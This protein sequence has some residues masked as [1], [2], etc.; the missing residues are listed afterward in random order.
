[1]IALAFSFIAAKSEPV[2]DTSSSEAM[3][4]SI[5]SILSFLPPEDQKKFN[6]TITGIYLSHILQLRGKNVSFDQSQFQLNEK[7]DGKTAQEIF[8]ISDLIQH[9]LIK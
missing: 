1:M 5:E 2:L 6:E 9:R 4:R 8:Q 3:K 7:L